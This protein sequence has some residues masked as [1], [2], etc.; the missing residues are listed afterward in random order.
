MFH[1]CLLF[2]CSFLLVRVPEITGVAFSPYL[3]SILQSQAFSGTSKPSGSL[4][5]SSSVLLAKMRQ[6]NA[7]TTSG[8]AEVG[9]GAAI[10]IHGD[11]HRELVKEIRDFI[12][13]Q[14]K[15]DGQATTAELLERFAKDLPSSDGALFRSMLY[16]I[17]DFSRHRGDG[18]WSL[19]PD[20]R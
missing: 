17:C 18:L 2:H 10:G 13:T 16:E 6:R 14:A 4:T 1:V 12:A 7:H 8:G 3:Q 9:L 11:R 5:T 15:V 19:K 20:F